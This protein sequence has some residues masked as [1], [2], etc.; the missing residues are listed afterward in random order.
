VRAYR[1]S[2]LRFGAIQFAIAICVAVVSTIIIFLGGPEVSGTATSIAA[3]AGSASLEGRRKARLDRA[4]PEDDE[5][6]RVSYGM[7]AVT[8]VV[9]IVLGVISVI[10]FRASG[11]EVPWSVFLQTPF[12]VVMI[13]LFLLCWLMMRFIFVSTAR[14]EIRKL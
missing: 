14:H 3:A 7:L 10:L 13:I 8:V 4:G 5:I 11:K 1:F 6:R 12:L 2:P 9:N